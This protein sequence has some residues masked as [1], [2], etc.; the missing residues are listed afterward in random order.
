VGHSPKKEVADVSER[1]HGNHPEQRLRIYRS[2]GEGPLPVLLYLHGVGFVGGGLDVVD[3]PARDLAVRTGAIVVAATY[4]RAPE[5]KFPAAHD[6]A[7]QALQW[8]YD[9]IWAHGGDRARLALGGDSAGAT[10]A[11][12]A[13][14]RAGQDGPELCAKGSPSP[15]TRSLHCDPRPGATR[16]S[17]D[18][19]GLH[20][21][22]FV[23]LLLRRVDP[24]RA[25]HLGGR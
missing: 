25:H 12:A 18:V 17:R 6:D 5:H 19:H 9:N 11:A 4:R 8:T 14:V 16:S 24:A 2:E 7:Y 15:T 23:G 22:G 3:E 13:A 20:R 10:L 21:P 1:A